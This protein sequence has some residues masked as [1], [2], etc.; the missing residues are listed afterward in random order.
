MWL[1]AF[2]PQACYAGGPGRF[3]YLLYKDVNRHA[4]LGCEV[5]AV[6]TRCFRIV[7]DEIHAFDRPF[8]GRFRHGLSHPR[9]DSQAVATGQQTGA[10]GLG[11]R[12]GA[13][14]RSPWGA[15][16]SAA[17]SS[18]EAVVAVA[19]GTVVRRGRSGRRPRRGPGRSTMTTGSR[20]S[21][22]K[23]SSRTRSRSR[24]LPSRWSSRVVLAVQPRLHVEQVRRPD[25]V[26]AQVEHGLVHE[27]SWAAPASSIQIRRMTVSIG[28]QV[29]S[30]ARRDT[31]SR[32]CGIPVIPPCARAYGPQLVETRPG[33][34]TPPCRRRPPRPTRESGIPHLEQD[35]TQRP[36]DPQ[37]LVGDDLVGVEPLLRDRDAGC[38]THVGWRPASPA[39]ASHRRRVPFERAT[40][41]PAQGR[42]PGD[43]AVRRSTSRPLRTIRCSTTERVHPSTGRTA[44]GSSDATRARVAGSGCRTE[45]AP[46]VGRA[47]ARPG[48]RR[49]WYV[50]GI[51]VTPRNTRP[52]SAV[53]ATRV[54]LIHRVSG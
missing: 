30:S 46:R 12:H 49:A 50:G 51:G 54:A 17:R 42:P 2:C 22:R 9:C 38:V 1:R 11:D 41:E 24:R 25:M 13:G 5:R 43:P 7:R 35:R 3:R 28:D 52:A 37:P 36:G 27:R 8:D 19:Q 44:H 45:D 21:R 4:P 20:P 16:R 14:P 26:S 31:A 39:G 32:A 18:S 34:R 48:G 47:P 6:S 23:A 15:T 40:A 53:T 33:P 10:V 29:F